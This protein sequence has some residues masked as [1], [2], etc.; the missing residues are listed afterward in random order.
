[1]KGILEYNLPDEQCEFHIACTGMD[2][3][4]C[5]D[6]LDKQLRSWLKYSN[7]F[8]SANEALEAVRQELHDILEC[9]NLRLEMLE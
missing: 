9:R 5:L 2:W 1:M 8:Q 3:A 7:E 4:L 6:D